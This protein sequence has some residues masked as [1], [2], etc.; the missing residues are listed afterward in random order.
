MANI[1]RSR[2]S[3]VFIR[4]GQRVRETQ[5]L[6]I[7]KTLATVSAAGAAV[8]LNSLNTAEKALRPFTIVR[9]RGMFFMR[10][11][12]VAAPEL[13]SVAIGGCVVSDQA[14]AIGVTAIPTPSTD[15]GSDLWFL[16]EENMALYEL[17]TFVGFDFD[18]GVRKEFDSKAMRKVEEGQDVVFV[19]E[20]TTGSLGATVQT[21]GRLLIKLH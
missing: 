15:R 10:S 7:D 3:G 13:Y 12:Q 1:I 4:G 2:K 8:L 19:L 11:D 17:G 16:Y 18:A 14:E 20:A 6:P 21:A 9:T 5:W